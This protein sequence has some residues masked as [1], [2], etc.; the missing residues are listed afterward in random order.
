ML[1]PLGSTIQTPALI[2]DPDRP[3]PIR[4]RE[5][6]YNVFSTKSVTAVFCSLIIQYAWHTDTTALALRQAAP[7]KPSD[8]L[9]RGFN[10]S[11]PR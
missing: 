9:T 3:A 11:D 6:P 8:F 10:V 4:A 5:I 2:T 7:A 1:T